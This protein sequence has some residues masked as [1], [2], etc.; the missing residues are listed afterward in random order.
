MP[1][2]RCTKPMDYP[3]GSLARSDSSAREAHFVVALD[4]KD[5]Q[6]EMRRKFPLAIRFEVEEWDP[7]DTMRRIRLRS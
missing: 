2:Y 5:A 1:M 4:S 7:S 3:P 6:K